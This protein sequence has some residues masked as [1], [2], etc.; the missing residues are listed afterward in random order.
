MVINAF[1]RCLPASDHA[2]VELLAEAV[3]QKAHATGDRLLRTQCVL[4]RRL[5]LRLLCSLA[6]QLAD[7]ADQPVAASAADTAQAAA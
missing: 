7:A 2:L 4:V 1:I 3:Q 6:A 5:L